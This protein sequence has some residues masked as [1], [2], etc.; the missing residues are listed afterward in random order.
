M[1]WEPPVL[2]GTAEQ[3]LRTAGEVDFAELTLRVPIWTPPEYVA[4]LVQKA[5]E[6]LTPECRSA[7]RALSDRTAGVFRFVMERNPTLVLPTEPHELTLQMLNERLEPTA[8]PEVLNERAG[9]HR[10]G[11]SWRTL[12]DEWN[13]S[14]AEEDRYS[15]RG[16]Y[17]AFQRWRAL[18][19][20][21]YDIG[22]IL[23]AAGF[24][25][26]RETDE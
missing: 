20:P 18:L 5:Q 4:L 14:H 24:T 21:R 8:P 23:E 2:P 12:L 1:D 3:A 15:I 22:Q 7:G 10:G 19:F 16:F 26:R 6:Q 17:T 25:R 13:G 9:T 11:A